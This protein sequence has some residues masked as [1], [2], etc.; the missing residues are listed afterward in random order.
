MQMDLRYCCVGWI[1]E[2][3]F[4][5]R[6]MAT[7]LFIKRIVQNGVGKGHFIFIGVC[8]NHSSQLSKRTNEKSNEGDQ[9][10]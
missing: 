7:Q 2:F 10:I 1:P 5:C 4:S 6:G 3:L 8:S 9:H